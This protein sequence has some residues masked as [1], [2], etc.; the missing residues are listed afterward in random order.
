MGSWLESHLWDS[1]QKWLL[2]IECLFVYTFSPVAN[3]TPLQE[4]HTSTVLTGTSVF[5]SWNFPFLEKLSN[6]NVQCW[7]AGP[8]CVAS[9][10]LC[11]STETQE[12]KFTKVTLRKGRDWGGKEDGKGKKWELPLSGQPRRGGHTCLLGR[13]GQAVSP[14]KMSAPFSWPLSQYKG[15]LCRSA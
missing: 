7:K 1:R 9:T 11:P 6:D 12:L 15:S 14:R 4:R 5:S 3:S 2:Q 13:Q 8:V 10:C